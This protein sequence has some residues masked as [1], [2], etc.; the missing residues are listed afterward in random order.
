MKR[1]SFVMGLIML[2]IF[3]AFVAIASGYPADARFMPFVV[4]IPAIGLCLLQIALDAGRRPRPAPAADSRGSFAVAE[5]TVSRMAGQK[6]EF[7][8][9]RGPKGL[10][11]ANVRPI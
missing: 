10:Q 3:C 1:S 7:D 4:G 8:V 11:A 6:V 5:E 2:A 9:V